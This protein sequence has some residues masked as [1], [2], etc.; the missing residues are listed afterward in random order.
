M[1]E[2]F[3]SVADV[4]RAERKL[5]R[6]RSAGLRKCLTRLKTL[7]D[8]FDNTGNN[9]QLDLA[10]EQISF[11]QNRC[12]QLGQSIEFIREASNQHA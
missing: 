10:A 1:A 8:T 2:T 3:V 12:Y 6:Q 5:V 4:V 7:L 11:I 9:S